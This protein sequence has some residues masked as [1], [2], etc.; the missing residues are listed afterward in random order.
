MSY[1]DRF[2]RLLY[3]RFYR[4]KMRRAHAEAGLCRDCKEPRVNKS[5]C[6]KHRDAHR[7]QVAGRK[8]APEQAA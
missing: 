5:H 4:R 1:A 6:A 7:A 2:D 3:M 8:R